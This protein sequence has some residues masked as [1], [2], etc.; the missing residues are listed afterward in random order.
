MQSHYPPS[1]NFYLFL[2]QQ[3]WSN[4]TT[5]LSFD[6]AVWSF[7]ELFGSWCR[8]KN[9]TVAAGKRV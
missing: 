9:L 8:N 4:K 7:D 6:A 5:P 3:Q 1:W 2:E